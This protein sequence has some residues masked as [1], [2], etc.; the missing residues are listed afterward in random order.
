MTE[1]LE[2]RAAISELGTA[3]ERE[4][5]VSGLKTIIVDVGNRAFL[6]FVVGRD[7]PLYTYALHAS[8]RTLSEGNSF[9]GAVGLAYERPRI[10]RL[11]SKQMRC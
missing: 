10:F 1:T 2:E 5:G 7:S 8:Q 11:L 6:K 9:R 3:F 4:V